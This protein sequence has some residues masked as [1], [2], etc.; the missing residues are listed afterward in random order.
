LTISPQPNTISSG[1]NP[2]NLSITNHMNEFTALNSLNFF[3][4]VGM[5]MECLP[6]YDGGQKG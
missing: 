4:K 5:H 2:K 3:D 1:L 6:E